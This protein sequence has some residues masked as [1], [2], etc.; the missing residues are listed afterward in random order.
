[1]AEERIPRA[2]CY[3]CQAFHLYDHA[4]LAVPLEDMSWREHHPDAQR[5][6]AHLGTR[7]CGYARQGCR[8][9]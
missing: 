2:Y 1:M 8:R 6:N 5:R 4:E 7:D 3:L 9:P